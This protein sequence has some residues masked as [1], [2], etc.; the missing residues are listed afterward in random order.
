MDARSDRTEQTDHPDPRARFR[1]A[2]NAL[3]GVT[4]TTRRLLDYWTDETSEKKLFFCQVEALEAAIYL[5]ECEAKQGDTWIAGDTRSA[6]S[7]PVMDANDIPALTVSSPRRRLKP[8][9]VRGQT[10]KFGNRR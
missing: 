6:C 5:T 4:P 7:V 10:E 2:P 1:L 9:Q 3:P 8:G